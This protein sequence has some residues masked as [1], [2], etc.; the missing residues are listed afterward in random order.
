MLKG[1][2][3]LCAIL[4]DQHAILAGQDSKVGALC[5]IPQPQPVVFPWR[6][7]EGDRLFGNMGQRQWGQEGPSLSLGE[8]YAPSTH[9]ETLCSVTWSL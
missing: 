6:N 9:R 2:Q 5:S 1:P 7:Y 3:Y 4:A 8:H